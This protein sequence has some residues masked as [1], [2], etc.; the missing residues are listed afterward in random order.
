M[1]Y[2]WFASA[3][4]R[5]LSAMELSQRRL[6]DAQQDACLS[7]TAAWLPAYPLAEGEVQ[8]RIDGSLLSGVSLLQAQA[9]NQRDLMLATE[10]SLNEMHKHLLRQL[11]QSGQ[12]PSYA[13]M[14][15]ALQLG[16]SSGS[17]VSK[18]SRQVGHFAATSFSSASLNAARDMRRVWK[19]QKP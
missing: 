5:Y 7:W 2:E 8:N 6:L 13:V 19:Q 10:K 14:K 4:Q 16:Q 17:A 1:A 12:H 9:D 18:M 3:F 15:Q 11:E